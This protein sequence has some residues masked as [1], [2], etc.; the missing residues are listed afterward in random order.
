[1]PFTLAKITFIPYSI[2]FLKTLILIYSIRHLLTFNGL[3]SIKTQLFHIFP[4]VVESYMLHIYHSFFNF[5][6]FFSTITFN[7]SSN[8]INLI[9]LNQTNAFP[10]KPSLGLTLSMLYLIFFSTFNSINS[11]KY[12]SN[13][14]KSI[15]TN[16]KTSLP[17][18]F[19]VDLIYNPYNL[20]L[21]FQFLSKI[22]Q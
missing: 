4:K 11:F 13:V 17:L 18:T 20:I 19:K 1:M 16:Q 15:K 10:I 6:H 8:T 14:I 9:K 3:K 7:N 2:I 21:S 22:S 12:S 5:F